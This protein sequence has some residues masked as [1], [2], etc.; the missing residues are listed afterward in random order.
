MPRSRPTESTDATPLK[1]TNKVT[2]GEWG[3]G[4]G[5]WG[6]STSTSYG[7]WQQIQDSNDTKPTNIYMHTYIDTCIYIYIYEHPSLCLPHVT[8]KYISLN[9]P[10]V[11]ST[12]TPNPTQY[13]P[14]FPAIN[15]MESATLSFLQPS[16]ISDFQPS[17]C[18]LLNLQSN[19]RYLALFSLICCGF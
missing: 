13:L 3:R 6:F 15:P 2:N 16:Q 11:I 9:L 12:K 8:R 7:R 19:L 14:Q 1:S 10:L 4:R 17:G 18:F 5:Q